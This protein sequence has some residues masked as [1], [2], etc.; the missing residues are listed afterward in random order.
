MLKASLKPDNPACAPSYRGIRFCAQS[1][2]ENAQNPLCGR[3]QADSCQTGGELHR[4]TA[5]CRRARTGCV[6]GVSGCGSERVSSAV[7]INRSFVSRRA[8]L[9]PAGRFPLVYSVQLKC[10][11][12]RRRLFSRF[13]PTFF[14]FSLHL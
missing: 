7:S 8:L 14:D 2:A 4:Y 3:F 6:K 1:V 12:A 10:F 9:F 11:S 13:P 5:A